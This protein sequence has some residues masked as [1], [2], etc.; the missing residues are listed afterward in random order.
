MIQDIFPKKFDNSFRFS[1]P[2]KDDRIMC[3]FGDDNGSKGELLYSFY[4]EEKCELEYPSALEMGLDG[5]GP[6]DIIYLFSVDDTGYFMPSDIKNTDVP[7]RYR[8]Y[9]LRELRVLKLTDNSGVFIAYCAYHLYKWYESS[10]FCGVCGSRTHRDTKE[11]ALVCPDC[12]HRVY[13]RLNPAVIVGV[14]KNDSLL[15]TRY[16]TGFAHNALIAGFTEFGETLEETVSREVMEETGLRVKNIRYYKSQPWGL[17][18]DILAGFFCEAEGDDDIKMD[19]GELKY[20]SFV[21]REDIE[22]Q[23]YDLSLTNEMMRIFKEGIER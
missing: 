17:A 2:K 19:E 13:P 20:A 5:T 14:K 22:L 10:R 12:S 15:I 3:F 6:K 16:R 11:R 23:P 21:R 18:M 7:E 8:G 4:D 1:S 9:G